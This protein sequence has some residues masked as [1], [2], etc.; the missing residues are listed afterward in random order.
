M[1]EQSTEPVK[2]TGQNPVSKAGEV[3][4]I[5]RNIIDYP[6]KGYPR[7]T[8]D[9]YPLEV[10]YDEFAYKRIVD[11][12]RDAIKQL[13]THLSTSGNNMS[14]ERVVSN[15]WLVKWALNFADTQKKIG[16]KELMRKMLKELGIEVEEEEREQEPMDKE[17][18]G[19]MKYHEL[20]DEDKLDRFGRRKQ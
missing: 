20:K 4:E 1:T 8:K 11:F 15:D 13:L 17:A 18:A 6:P 16:K 19:D 2:N 7:R 9:G 10:S 3:E 5:I 14:D 12:Y